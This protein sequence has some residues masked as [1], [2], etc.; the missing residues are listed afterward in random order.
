M[1]A[2]REREASTTYASALAPTAP[3][4]LAV[5]S[6]EE[7]QLLTALCPLRRQTPASGYQH[8]KDHPREQSHCAFRCS[9]RRASATLLHDRMHAHGIASSSSSSSSTLRSCCQLRHY[10]RT[11]FLLR[12]L[13]DVPYAY[14]R[15]AREPGVRPSSL[16]VVVEAPRYLSVRARSRWPCVYMY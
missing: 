9:A 3:S 16:I 2:R 10:S 12:T 6:E 5:E 13:C 4:A 11:G 15:E 8:R 1:L 7:N 14:R